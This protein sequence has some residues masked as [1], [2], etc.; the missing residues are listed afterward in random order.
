MFYVAT[1]FWCKICF[2]WGVPKVIEEHEKPNLFEIKSYFDVGESFGCQTSIP[3]SSIFK[4][5]WCEDPK[6]I[7]EKSWWIY[8]WPSD[9]SVSFWIIWIGSIQ[10]ISQPESFFISYL[11]CSISILSTYVSSRF[12]KPPVSSTVHQGL[13]GLLPWLSSCARATDSPKRA[14][15]T[16]ANSGIGLATAMAL[17][18]KGWE[19]LPLCRSPQKLRETL[20]A[21]RLEIGDEWAWLLCISYNYIPIISYI[22][23]F[24]YI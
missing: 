17:A 11:E 18:E 19:V 23:I 6:R 13:Q 2:L 10:N 3:F 8:I 5:K 24:L 7:T 22:Y 20:E 21:T 4:T 1:L 16:G 14:L 12:F 15:I 9:L